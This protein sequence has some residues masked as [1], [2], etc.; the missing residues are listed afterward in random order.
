MVY[1]SSLQHFNYSLLNPQI[2]PDLTILLKLHFWELP[3]TS[4]TQ[5]KAFAQ[6]PLVLTLTTLPTYSSLICDAAK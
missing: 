3:M 4:E 6:F 1:T 2:T 5:R